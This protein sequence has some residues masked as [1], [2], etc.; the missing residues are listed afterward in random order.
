MKTTD[1]NLVCP[2]T[3]LRSFTE[4]ESL[5]FKGRD[6]QVDQIVELL[7]SNK[8]LMLTGASGEGKSSLV[9]GGLIPNA[10]AGFFKAQYTNWMVADFRPEREPVS[11]MSKALAK[12]FNQQHST[13]ETEIK[14]GFSSLVDLYT[15]SDYY[16]DETDGHWMSLSDSEKKS[17][18]RG[19]ANL[20]ILVDQFEEFF[21]NPENFSNE[22]PSQDSQVVVNVIL[23]TARIALRR[24]LPIYVV[25]TMRS[26]YI[27]QCAAFRGLPEYIGFSQ[28]FV[29]RLKRKDLK[30]VIEEPALLSGNRISQRLIERL[31]YDLEEGVDQ[32]PILQHALSQIWLA[33]DHGR[34]EMDLIHY[35]MVG[36]MDSVDLPDDNQKEFQYWF[37]KLPEHKRNYFKATG[38]NKVIEIH[39][40]SLYEEAYAYHN[41]MEGAEPISKQ[42]AKRIVA[43]TFSCLTKIDNSRA[44]RN[45]MSLQEITDII[46]IPKLNTE[47]VGKV[48]NIYREEGNSFIRPFKTQDPDTHKLLPE[49]V[50][51]ITHESL[52]RNWNKLDEWA[53]TEFNYYTTYLDYSTQLKRWKE[54]GKSRNYLLPIG[55]LAYFENWYVQC[56]P[57]EG[58]IKRYA[59]TST[60]GVVA[61]VEANEVLS[62]IRE[63]LKRSA[64]KVAIARAFMKYGTQRIAAFLAI[65][66]MLSLS[67]FYWYD[68]ELKQNDQVIKNLRS[69]AG[70]LLASPEV[71]Y[72]QKA[73]YLLVEERLEP[74]SMMSYLESIDLK[75]KIGIALGIYQRTIEVSNHFKA[76]IKDELAQFIYEMI[77]AEVIAS[78]EEFTLQNRNKFITLLAY[79]EYYNPNQERKKFIK[80]LTRIN[81][82]LVKHF[83]NT[84][85]L[86]K[87]TVPVELNQA[88]QFWLT[89]GL[90][91]DEEVR[92]LIKL[93]SSDGPERSFKTFN[94][95]YP[96]GSFES[97]GRQ[98]NDFNG[99]YHT[100]ASLYGAVGDL[101]SV[102]WCFK[103]IIENGQMQYLEQAGSF[104]NHLNI[105]GYLYQYGHRDKAL[106]L[107]KW[108][109]TNTKDNPPIT[110][111][112]NL[113]IRA[114]YNSWLYGYN[115]YKQSN[116]YKGYFNP[117]LCMAERSIFY[118]LMEDYENEINREAS[119]DERNYLMAMNAK[120]KAIFIHRY[121]TSRGVELNRRELENLLE[122]G[123]NH[124]RMI[125]PDYQLGKV[126]I[127][128]PY[129][130]DGVR[131]RQYSRRELFLYPD[132]MDG[133]F[134]RPFHSNLF[135]NYLKDNNL[136]AELYQTQQDLEM[137]HL[138]LSKAFEKSPRAELDYHDYDALP[139]QT[140]VSI[141]D[142][143]ASHPQGSQ[144][145][146]NLPVIVLANRALEYGH[147]DI[148]L[149]Y[150]NKLDLE[151]I[152]RS[153]DRYEY[154]EKTFF[155]NQMKDLS[156]NLALAGYA[157]EAI[158][159]AEHM[160]EQTQRVF[161][162]IAM[163]DHVYKRN[164]SPMVFTYL[165][166]VVSINKRIDFNTIP[167]WLDNRFLLVTVLSGIGGRGMNAKA[168]EIMR[169][170][171]LNDR[172]F[173]T[174]LMIW[175]VTKE[176]N[177]YRALSAIPPSFTE[178]LDL[179]CRFAILWEECKKRESATSASEWKAMDEFFLRGTGTD[180]IFYQPN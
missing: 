131:T 180:Y 84:T 75:N 142:F 133:W 47:T 176:G 96:K 159:L 21:T 85:D 63:F 28:F 107:I 178:E 143:V 151:H 164:A 125:S 77:S 138:W 19:G 120:R 15:T 23:E 108:I 69:H 115:V 141:L 161:S 128:V 44:V 158:V 40:N 129:F 136:L 7:A 26:D 97:N 10:R 45:R 154:L 152:Q 99:G 61:E 122:K 11:N 50:L 64:R 83:F 169:D 98:T 163:A 121:N 88:I 8:F 117:N 6:S 91:K 48:I 37:V 43:L 166:S 102:R 162:Y 74:G 18:K 173:G 58:W 13:I 71:G 104:N 139:D 54:N 16:T 93:I 116:A 35:A 177:Y 80:D 172:I 170:F 68:A 86:Y 100:L 111:F 38:L 123:V 70:V 12:V 157:D 119:D 27:G 4:E 168:L 2:Y 153:Y 134:D 130:T 52:I 72:N 46:N 110:L 24:G 73:D 146:T 30:Q 49:T 109:S 126:S 87:P 82:N 171:S 137:I 14:R 95:Y 25:C 66:I 90:P 55:P 65:V 53:T 32:L 113:V 132:Y 174:F 41:S 3:G 34:E 135:Y 17:K 144:F 145:D 22:T 156:V 106:E 76:P 118:A 67:G 79:D 165:D 59:K 81:Y 101:D 57:N 60:D 78:D 167:D 124:F 127:T 175:G 1:T 39:A 5:Y 105:I 155:L 31:V 160:K 92:D 29:P 150:F 9:Y 148:G 89:F 140:L 62:D 103:S 94:T 33:A 179:L 114:G 36:G 51:D 56:K 147:A 20:L 42:E 149:S 112:R